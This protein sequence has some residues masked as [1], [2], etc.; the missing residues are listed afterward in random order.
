MFIHQ[1]L[2]TSCSR[3]GYERAHILIL[4][5]SVIERLYKKYHHTS[6][7]LKRQNVLEGK[8]SCLEYQKKDHA[9]PLV[10]LHQPAGKVG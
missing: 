8:E 3:L 10:Y 6:V 5:Q 1:N 4:N 7:L 9:L 2:Q